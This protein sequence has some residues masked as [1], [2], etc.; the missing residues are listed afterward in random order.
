VSLKTQELYALVFLTRYLDL[1]TNFIS[2]YNTLMKL[3]FLASSGAIVYYMRFHKV[4]KQ[5][6][7][8]D[9][10]TFRTLFL[11]LPCALLALF[12]NERA[13][14]LEVSPAA[15]LDSTHPLLP[16]DSLPVC[17]LPVWPTQG[18]RLL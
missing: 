3:I 16:M 2:L 5:K 6:Y 15:S 10:D 13:K 18:H 14:I 4:V 7:D 11:V 1:F 8:K 12:I 9:Q 17:P